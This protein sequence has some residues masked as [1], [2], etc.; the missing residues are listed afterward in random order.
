MHFDIDAQ[1][2]TT[3]NTVTNTGKM[4]VH[5]TMTSSKVT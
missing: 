4:A 2:S 1:K 3:E 5:A